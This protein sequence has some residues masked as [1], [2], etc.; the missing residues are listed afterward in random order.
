MGQC[1]GTVLRQAQT[2]EGNPP[3][4]T[5]GNRS[6][7]SVNAADPQ[8]SPGERQSWGLQHSG[9][10]GEGTPHNRRGHHLLAQELSSGKWAG[11]PG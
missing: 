5:R 10:E 3:K 4:G 2:G 7:R 6:S 1:R 8:P 9:G 11:E